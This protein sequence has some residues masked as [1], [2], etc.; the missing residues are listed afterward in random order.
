MDGVHV[1]F[2][3]AV[4]GF[5]VIDTINHLGMSLGTVNE[6]VKISNCGVISPPEPGTFDYD[7]PPK[8]KIWSVNKED[9]PQFAT[10][11]RKCNAQVIIFCKRAKSKRLWVLIQLR[12]K[13]QT[14]MPY[15]LAAIGGKYDN[16][17]DK[18]SRITAIREIMEETGCHLGKNTRLTKFDEGANCD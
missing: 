9:S 18:H 10:N 5:R 3:H 4:S 2:G 8:Q 7:M 17:D 1:V 14:K 12:S 16:Q 11:Y 15:H 13:N 6:M